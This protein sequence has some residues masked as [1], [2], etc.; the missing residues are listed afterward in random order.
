[1]TLTAVQ[2][3][4]CVQLGNERLAAVEGQSPVVAVIMGSRSD[5]ETMRHAASTLDELVIAY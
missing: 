1:M 5:W 3:I 4:G 2:E